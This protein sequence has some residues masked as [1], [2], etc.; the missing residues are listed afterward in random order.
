MAAWDDRRA[1]VDG[2]PAAAVECDPQLRDTSVLAV[3]DNG[4]PAAVLHAAL[5]ACEAEAA[6]EGERLHLA[7]ASERGAQPGLVAQMRARARARYLAE[8]LLPALELRGRDP[9]AADRHGFTA[10]HHAA[11]NG[12]PEA[13]GVL[14]EAGSEV[15]A[16]TRGGQTP[17]LLASA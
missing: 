8:V 4:D 15:D 3:I 5:I 17:L 10:L 16:V 12:Q 6:Q 9:N 11:L 7:P 14:L 13:V 1:E 2:Q